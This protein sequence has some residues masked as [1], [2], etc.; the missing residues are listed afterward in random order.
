MKK[1]YIALLFL[2]LSQLT[3]AQNPTFEWAKQMGKTNYDDGYSITTDAEGNIYVTGGF[4]G[5]VDFDSGDETAILTSAG[6][7]DIF[8]QKLDSV[9]NLLW[10]K[11]M[12]GTSTDYGNSITIDEEGNVYTAG[13]FRETVDFDP[14]DGTANL[15]SA[16]YSDI[17]IQKLD[18]DGNLLWVKQMG[19][20][21]WDEGF[22]ITTDDSGNVYTT[23]YF[24]FIVDFDPGEGIAYLN[25]AGHY[26]IFIQKLDST[27]KFLW[28]K[29][30][31]GNSYDLG[32][33]IT[34]DAFDNVYT[35][36]C[37]Q[38]TVDFD[39]GTKISNLISVDTAEIFIQKL[40]Q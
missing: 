8:I 28:A 23:G 36:G 18:T 4:K 25:S 10:V 24:K 21:G 17:Y 27:G 5:T 2:I 15:T 14:G 33:C 3:I 35:V 12:G 9:G 39:P 19:G 29:Q 13:Y 30:M 38:G 6:Y 32:K 34:T 22:S 40:S 20:P 37:F 16:G 7:R 31:G 26:D 11:Q 1:L